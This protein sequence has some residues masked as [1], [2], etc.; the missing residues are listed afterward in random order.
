[1]T[2]E[3]LPVDVIV[4]VYNAATDVRRCVDSVLA[5]TPRLSR[6]VLIDD[7]SPDPAIG[8]Y[9][10]ALAP[11]RDARIELLRNDRNLGFTATA[12]RGLRASTRD[13][14][15]LN[16]DTIVTTGW[17]EALVACAASDPR[18]ATVTPFSN[19]AEICSFPRI[20]EAH[21]VPDDPERIAAA[22][23][24]SA[25]PT[26]PDLPTGVGFCMLVRRAAIDAVGVFDLAFGAG[27]GEENDF[28]LRA[29]RAGFRNALADDAY[30]VHTGGRSFAGRK[31]E[32]GSRNL[33]LLLQRFP[34][35]EAMVRDY[36]AVDP[37]RAIRGVASSRLAR[38]AGQ[39]GVLQVVD[40]RVAN[41]GIDADFAPM[42]FVCRYYVAR[43]D[44]D[45]WR[46]EDRAAGEGVAFDLVRDPE[47]SWRDFARALASTFGVSIVHASSA[48]RVLAPV[49]DAW[50]EIG[51]SV[52]DSMD[53]VIA[54]SI[55]PTLPDAPPLANVRLRDALGYRA[56]KAAASE[57]SSLP[58]NATPATRAGLWQRIAEPVIGA[59]KARLGS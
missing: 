45:R 5:R 11:Q 14:V 10:R 4:P 33:A 35:Y 1:M 39:P 29:A 9:F 57:V 28:C 54:G 6:L 46:V 43:V 8:E 17:L 36:I 53:H 13:V 23:R 19:N 7:G 3:A 47:E 48:T 24:A 20:C 30:V 21:P 56:W 15:L 37:L 27:Y 12:N 44:D 31:D 38:D 22:L 16:S 32:L 55:A 52:V 26:Y 34:H 42:P 58:I 2:S 50:R 49:V 51:I 40:T 25:V 18:I 59:L 41:I